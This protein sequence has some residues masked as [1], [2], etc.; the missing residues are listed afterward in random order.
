[1]NTTMNETA[2]EFDAINGNYVVEHVIRH[3]FS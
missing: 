3:Q 2:P 1:M